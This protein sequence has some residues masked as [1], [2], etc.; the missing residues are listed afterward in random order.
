MY[1]VRLMFVL[2]TFCIEVNRNQRHWAN[3]FPW[4][5]YNIN[6]IDYRATVKW[7][8]SILVGEQRIFYIFYS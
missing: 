2:F 4:E 5:L 3:G 1:T 7:I 8:G 6:W